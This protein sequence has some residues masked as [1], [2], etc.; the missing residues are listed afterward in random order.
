MVT[1]VI[2]ATEHLLEIEDLP[3]GY[4]QSDPNHSTIEFSVRNMGIVD[5]KGVFREFTATVVIGDNE[6]NSQCEI[7]VGS[8]DTGVADR[9]KHLLSEEFFDAESYPLITFQSNQL[10]SQLGSLSV[11]GHLTLKG[12]EQPIELEAKLRGPQI[13]PW[14]GTRIGAEVYASINRYDFGLD[15]DKSTP[16]EVPLASA[17][18]QMAMHLGLVLKEDS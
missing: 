9:D 14:G 16:D 13:D 2:E 6:V 5:I 4:W 18:V 10:E 7:Q 1:I 12:R 11:P 8:L 15:W 3:A 17:E